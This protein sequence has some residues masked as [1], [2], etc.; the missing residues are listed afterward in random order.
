MLTLLSLTHTHT[1]TLFSFDISY[2][3][4]DHFTRKTKFPV[5]RLVSF[6]PPPS[7]NP[8]V[9]LKHPSPFWSQVDGYIFL[10]R[11]WLKYTHD[12]KIKQVFFIF[13]LSEL[14]SEKK[15]LTSLNRSSTYQGPSCCST[16]QKPTINYWSLICWFFF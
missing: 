11:R 14:F 13:N 1:H 7:K 15:R 3:F 16:L 2:F 5:T 6:I 10:L 12:N 4:M 8:S 9:I